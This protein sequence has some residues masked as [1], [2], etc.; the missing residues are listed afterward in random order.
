VKELIRRTAK[1]K[2][3]RF[4]ATS[5]PADDLVRLGQFFTEL[6]KLRKPPTA[7][8]DGTGTISPEQSAEDMK[9]RFAARW[10][11]DRRR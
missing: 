6:A 9:T 10:R 5:V 1:K 3:E 4:A 11:H 7:A 8:A 2:P